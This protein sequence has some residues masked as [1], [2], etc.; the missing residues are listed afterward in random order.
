MKQLSRETVVQRAASYP[1]S[2][3]QHFLTLTLLS[4]KVGLQ[5]PESLRIMIRYGPCGFLRL[6]GGRRCTAL[7]P[8]RISTNI[9]QEYD[10]TAMQSILLR[11]QYAVD[12]ILIKETTNNTVLLGALSISN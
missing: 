11:I 6:G 2:H 10:P 12:R 9:P 1:V 8:I 5:I 7:T 3:I 4:S